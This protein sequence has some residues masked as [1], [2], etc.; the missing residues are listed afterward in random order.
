MTYVMLDQSKSVLDYVKVLPS[1]TVI[2]VND[3]TKIKDI[4]DDIDLSD[5]ILF[6]GNYDSHDV[7]E[8]IILDLIIDGHRPQQFVIINNDTRI[9]DLLYSHGYDN[10]LSRFYYVGE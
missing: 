1:E 3:F 9:I 4:L 8:E 5:T 6:V 2:D 7:Y 10:H